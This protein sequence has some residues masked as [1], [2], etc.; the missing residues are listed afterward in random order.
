MR[1]LGKFSIH[2]YV[3]S[4]SLFFLSQQNDELSDSFVAVLL[5]GKLCFCFH[6]RLQILAG[7][8]ETANIDDF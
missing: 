8:R 6:L 2:A 7:L 4:V 5:V 3:V 1:P